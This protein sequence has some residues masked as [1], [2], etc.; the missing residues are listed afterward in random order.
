LKV[1]LIV[2]VAMT[3]TSCYTFTATVGNGPQ[4]GTQ[5]VAHNHY[6]IEG[7]AP[8]STAKTNELVG[9]AKD[10]SITVKHTF[11]DGLISAITA[12]FY[13]PTTVIVTK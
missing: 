13:T 5:I 8:V 4:N 2:A 1:I 10:Y 11:V 9:N 12:G 7:L 3:M 6:L